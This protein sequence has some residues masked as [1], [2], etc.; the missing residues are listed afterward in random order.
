MNNIKK[1]DMKSKIQISKVIAKLLSENIK[2]FNDIQS[3]LYMRI[4]N[5]NFSLANLDDVDNNVYYNRKNNTIYF[6]S[7]YYEDLISKV[8]INKSLENSDNKDFLN[9]YLVREVI[10]GLRSYNYK[11]INLKKIEIEGINL[12]LTEYLTYRALKE[13]LR[14]V[15]NDKYIVY[16][17]TEEKEKYIT[18]LIYEILFLQDKKNT[19]NK[20][21]IGDREFASIIKKTYKDNTAR[22]LSGFQSIINLTQDKEYDED[23]VFRIFSK[24]QEIIYKTYFENVNKNIETIFDVDH[25]VE[26][27]EEF[28]RIL[29]IN[30]VN[31]DQDEDVNVYEFTKEENEEQIS[32]IE[33]E[34]KA[35][36]DQMEGLYLKTYVELSTRGTAGTLSIKYNNI[37]E[38]IF[39]RI[40]I[41]IKRKK[42]KIN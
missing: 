24:I 19:K 11:I 27:L 36:K 16:S 9:F 35:F 13:K 20:L 33:K 25:Q 32:E 18:S 12:A 2:E 14:K 38:K 1:I 34:F 22:I 28:D 29:G 37:F 39:D 3:E 42:A 26:K 41:F 15:E 23:K 21:I 6:D 40:N 31:N 10:K 30:K 4:F 8:N 5:M 17:V 7:S